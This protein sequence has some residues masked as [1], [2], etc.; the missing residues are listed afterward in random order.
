M[1]FR[2]LRAEQVMSKLRPHVEGHY[3]TENLGSGELL[4]HIEM[5][6][7]ASQVLH[8]GNP[9]GLIYSL[10]NQRGGVEDD[11]LG[12][13]TPST[14]SVR[15]LDIRATFAEE[16]RPQARKY[17]IYERPRTLHVLADYSDRH[18][19][20]TGRQTLATLGRVTVG[21]TS[22]ATELI[23]AQMHA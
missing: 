10:D 7:K 5:N 3:G 13:F 2:N 23:Q 18:R 12:P 9:G 1:P 17:Q 15:N 11:G 22:I 4:D 6:L 19:F 16:G 21:M 8:A 14:D 20:S